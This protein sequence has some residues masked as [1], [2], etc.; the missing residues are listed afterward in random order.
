MKYVRLSFFFI[1]LFVSGVTVSAQKKSDWYYYSGV[2]HSLLSSFDMHDFQ[3]D[4]TSSSEDTRLKSLEIGLM[5]RSERNQRNWSGVKLQ[6]ISSYP[7]ALT[8]SM[9]AWVGAPG[10]MIQKQYTFSDELSVHMTEIGYLFLRSFKENGRSGVFINPN[11]IFGIMTQ[12]FTREFDSEYNSRSIGIDMSTG[13][14]WYLLKNIALKGVI[15]YRILKLKISAFDPGR[16]IDW[17]G[18]YLAAGICIALP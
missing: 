6:V 12:K 3:A 7:G 13:F 1:L 11:I 16:S 4:W 8:R 18:P 9:T 17:S 5:F 15:G 2:Q 10:T 14:A